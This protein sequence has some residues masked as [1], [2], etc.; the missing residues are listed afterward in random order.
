MTVYLIGFMGSGK[1]T[2]GKVLGEMLDKSHADTDAL[3]E[4]QYGAISDI[5]SEHGQDT[6]RDHESTV[7]QNISIEKEII[8]TGGGI[9]ERKKNISYMKEN[10]IIVYLNTSF[11]EIQKRLM[12][13][14]ERPLWNTDIQEKEKLF[15]RRS[16]M[17]QNCADITILTDHKNPSDIADATR[18]LLDHYN[19]E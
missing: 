4:A 11:T 19:K 1:S 7:L 16:Q 14:S 6:F 13:D 2:V 12:H 15:Q 10:G 9:V 18:K 3:I 5:F 8:S 17:Y